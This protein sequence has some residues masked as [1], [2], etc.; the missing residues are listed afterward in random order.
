MTRIKRGVTASKRRKKVLISDQIE[1]FDDIDDVEAMIV[2]DIKLYN[3][4][5]LL[6]FF[7][8]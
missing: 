6:L 4:F 2:S 7:F 8:L 1:N 5:F 3:K